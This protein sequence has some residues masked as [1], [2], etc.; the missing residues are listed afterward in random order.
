MDV[1]DRSG[2]DHIGILS[3]RLDGQSLPPVINRPRGTVTTEMDLLVRA[4][5]LVP[6]AAVECY[7]RQV[8]GVDTS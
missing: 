4:G 1:S 8:H 6:P 7:L 2:P 3:D 5:P